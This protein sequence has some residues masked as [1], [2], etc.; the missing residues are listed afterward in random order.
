MALSKME[1]GML[2]KKARTLKSEKYGKNYTQNE[3]AK[4]IGISRSYLGDIER[5]RIYP[6]YILL[7]K[8]AEACEV[9]FN[10]FDEKN[11]NP[12]NAFESLEK[13][14]ET[15]KSFS[16]RLIDM[17]LEQEFF[18]DPEKIPEDTLNIIIKALKKDIERAIKN[19]N[20]NK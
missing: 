18:D 15:T 2:I 7:N 5:G 13:D 8:I 3:L 17:L 19:K 1:M 6:N 11:L 12:Q 20:K 16:G 4:D 10:F 14:N 9:T